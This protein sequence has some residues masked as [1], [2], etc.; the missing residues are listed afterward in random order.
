MKNKHLF[1]DL[2]AV[3]I[4]TFLL[5][6]SVRYFVLPFNILSGGV[7]GIAVALSPL[8]KME[9]SL[10]ANTLMLLL[11]ILGGLFLGRK[12]VF[13]TALSSLLYPVFL[14]LL[15]PY[16]MKL[17]IDPLLASVY[18]GVLAGIGV[19]IVFR[20]GGSTGGM[21]VPAL[22]INKWFHTPLPSV[23]LIVDA[24]TILL[25][26]LVFGVE[27][28]LVGLVSAYTC[29]ITIDKV[30]VFGGNHAK[31]VHIISN[32]YEEITQMI[33][34]ELD[35]GTTDLMASGGY[36]KQTRPVILCAVLANQ[37]P[38]LIRRVHEIDPEAFVIAT[39][40]NEIRGNGFMGEFRV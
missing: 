35:R 5:V 40:A 11:F 30:L 26:M 9:A 10:I 31:A 25:G 37:Y 6:V 4:G 33:H 24:I 12:F 21:D 8:L 20:F 39:D 36:T 19:G 3:I 27:A 32:N 23:V 29:S 17:A 7:A 1:Q 28:V 14:T 22:I 2:S 38:Y 18:A 15:M 13:K 16:P 34:D